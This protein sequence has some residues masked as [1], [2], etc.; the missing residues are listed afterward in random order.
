MLNIIFQ[1]YSMNTKI[2]INKLNEKRVINWKT[3]YFPI[4]NIQFS[5]TINRLHIR[6]YPMNTFICLI[7]YISSGRIT[8]FSHKFE[9]SLE[10]RNELHYLLKTWL[11][12][13]WSMQAHSS[14][15]S[16]NLAIEN[17]ETAARAV[18]AIKLDFFNYLH[19]CSLYCSMFWICKWLH[20]RH[21]L[22]QA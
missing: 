1:F 14:A 5:L 8:F 22:G 4:Q 11:I 13:I 7:A 6:Q 18:Y 9:N 21:S 20:S 17:V 15:E 10:K 3:I 16:T 12:C 2:C 19:L